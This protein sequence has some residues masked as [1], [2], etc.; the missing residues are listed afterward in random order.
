LAVACGAGWAAAV[1]L[2]LWLQAADAVGQSPFRVPP[3]LLASYAGQVAAGRAALL[4][5]GCALLTM[6]LGLAAARTGGADGRSGA[7]DR[8]RYAELALG[9]GLL[10]ALAGP[11][12]G[13]VNG[14]GGHD[15]AVLAVA[16][17]V[18]AAC[19]WV[20]GLLAVVVVLADQPSLAAQTLPRFSTLAG[21]CAGV[22]AL[23]G[24][25]SA[26]LRLPDAAALLGTGYGQLVVAKTG[27]LLGLVALGWWARRGLLPRLAGQQAAGHGRLAG[28]QAAGH[29]RLA[30]QQAAGRG[31]RRG[32]GGGDA[33]RA[34]SVALARWLGPELALMAV[35]FGLAAALAGSSPG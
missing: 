24:V 8:P 5:L 16:L 21:Y 3:V 4:T 22:V 27:C 10:G 29:G 7:G 33:R 23:S 30:G 9:V 31:R 28:Q 26:A 14:P 19:V 34:G 20:G 15:P 11:V 12:T 32:P 35:V 18:T 13:H 6:A 17:H 1:L 25:L 2:G